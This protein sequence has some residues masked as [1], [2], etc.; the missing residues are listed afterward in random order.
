M[1]M[2]SAQSTPGQM[3]VSSAMEDAGLYPIGGQI[4][5]TKFTRVCRHLDKI[6][7]VKKTKKNGASTLIRVAIKNNI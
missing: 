6:N 1:Q 5:L 4:F 7:T 2:L 3:V